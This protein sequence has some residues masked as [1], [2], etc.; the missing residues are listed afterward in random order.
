MKNKK[1]HDDLERLRNEINH[2][3]TDDIESRKKLNRIIGDLEAKLEKPDDN[4]DGLVKDIKETIQHF[5]TEH[6]RATAILNDIMV[7]LSNMGI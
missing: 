1:L 4:D 2:L 5:E 6:P 7:T 3:A